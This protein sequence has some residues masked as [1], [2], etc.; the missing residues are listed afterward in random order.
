VREHF[1]EK[2]FSVGQ[3]AGEGEASGSGGERFEAEM[4]EINRRADIPRIRQDEAAR[5]MK[6][7]K[8]RDRGSLI[9]HCDN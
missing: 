7:A 5:L 2:N 9:V 8:L 1:V 4:L 3:A 6:G